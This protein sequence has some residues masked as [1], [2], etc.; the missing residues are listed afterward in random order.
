MCQGPIVRQA[1]QYFGTVLEHPADPRGHVVAQHSFP[2]VAPGPANFQKIAHHS[3]SIPRNKLVNM[4]KLRKRA[5]NSLFTEPG[6]SFE[7]GVSES[8]H[9]GNAPGEGHF[10][11]GFRADADLVFMMQQPDSRPTG[12]EQF[13][14]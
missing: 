7:Q 3:D 11:P 9:H 4:A 10:D 14:R 13:K 8:E 12:V 2:A 1:D 5:V 6:G